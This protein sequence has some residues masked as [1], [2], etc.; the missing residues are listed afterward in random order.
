MLLV[1]TILTF[2][3]LLVIDYRRALT[4]KY[5]TKLAEKL[6]LSVYAKESFLSKF[7]EIRGFYKGYMVRIF[8]YHPKEST[9][10]IK[11]FKVRTAIEIKIDN[12]KKYKLS[13]YEE[14]P[15]GT[16]GKYL[17]M[18]DVVIGHSKFDKEYIVK[19]NNEYITKQILTEQ[20]CDEL[21]YMANRRFGFEFQFDLEN[22]YYEEPIL[23]SNET[24]ALWIERVLNM[25]IEVYDEFNKHTK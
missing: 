11:P 13:I 23:I 16:L 17:G 18:Q 21:V 19:T 1:L 22:I 8:M 25:L 10:K 3:I 20:I 15:I 5:F 7:P 6:N 2:I 4:R 14:G 9:K 12:P 24:R